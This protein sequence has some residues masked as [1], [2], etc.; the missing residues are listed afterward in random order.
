VP[1]LLGVAHFAGERVVVTNFGLLARA[2]SGY[3][4][5][6]EERIGGLI[7]EVEGSARSGFVS[8]QSGLFVE[9]GDLCS[10]QRGARSARNDWLLDLSAP[11]G[12]E[13]D[14]QF[15]LVQAA[16]TF[17][18]S[19]E[20]AV[21]GENFGVLHAFD[22]ES[23]FEQLAAGSASHL[24]VAGYRTDPRAFWLGHS[25]DG[26]Q[27]WLEDAPGV[28]ND[29]ATVRLGVVDSTR[30]EAVFLIAETVAGTGQQL[31]RFDADAREATL[32]LQLEDG[33]LFGGMAF[34]DQDVWVAGRRREV[35]SLYR[36]PRASLA[37][38]R[39][40]DEAPPLECLAFED[41]VL[42]GCV[43]DFTYGSEFVL[44]SSSDGGRTWLPELTLADLGRVTSCGEDC[45]ATVDALHGT[46]GTLAGGDAG[47]QSSKRDAG[48]SAASHARAAGCDVHAR[49]SATRSWL[50]L[51]LAIAASLRR[52][53][54]RHWRVLA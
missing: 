51:A 38:E 16:D 29:Y 3:R 6:C 30:P 37:F 44:G 17:E 24:F 14:V 1:T 41:D 26:G 40:V 23:G 45:K 5:T 8:T 22:P 35:G 42:L 10:W 33:E 31:W 12:F 28:D 39:V 25:D 34:A 27:S 18:L 4:L 47:A 21:A 32:V 2:A 36:A 50:W 53:G 43:N 19:V 15:A 7:A 49:G 54:Q 20:R 11:D 13:D 52:A 9:Q 46:Y 48:A